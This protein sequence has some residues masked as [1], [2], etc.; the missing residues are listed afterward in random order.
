MKKEFFALS[1]K[2]GE[3]A[4]A[5]DAR[6]RRTGDGD[7][8]SAGRRV[9]IEQATGVRPIHPLEVIARLQARRVSRRRGG[10]AGAPKENDD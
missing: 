7:R 3:K 1:M 5:R 8:L 2:W 4:F 9:Q 10:A 6:S